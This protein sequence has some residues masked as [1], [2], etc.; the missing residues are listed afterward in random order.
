[1][2]QLTDKHN[3]CGCEACAQ[4]CPHNCITM[5]QDSEGF[6]YPHIDL[7]HCTNCGVCERTCPIINLPPSKKYKYALA[8]K[9][10]DK[11][12]L[13]KSSSG[14]IFS[15]IAEFILQQNGIVF[16]AKFNDKWEV[17][18]D[19]TESSDNL[20]EFRRSKYVQSHIGESFK[21]A[22]RFLKSGKLVLFTGTPCQINGLKLY[23]K[24]EYENLYTI[25]IA[26]HGVPSPKIWQLYLNEI[27]TT[28]PQMYISSI[29]FRDKTNGWTN[30]K[31]K[32]ELH[33]TSDNQQKCIQM[34]YHD[35][36]FMKA[37]LQNLI[38]RPSCEDC[39]IKIPKNLSD[40]TIG[41]LWGVSET[42]PEFDSELGISFLLANTNKG[43]LLL[44]KLNIEK[45]SIDLNKIRIYNGGL[46]NKFLPHKDRELYFKNL[47]KMKKFSCYTN[48]FVQ[49]TFITKLKNKFKQY[50]RK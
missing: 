1:M 5:R 33:S 9:A 7:T 49:I 40:I 46:L 35:N 17:I 30:Y 14:G 36:I 20:D 28:N 44:N 43:D 41:D 6:L 22:E 16:G 13:I 32:L 2:L 23:L 47:S 29:N 25:S 37:F 26:C 34:D 24:K 19:Y 15:L 4:R 3:C 18:H 11:D 38:L 8:A 45:R 10:K 27:I 12:I 48:K 31:F 50:I 42:Y 21:K 39:K